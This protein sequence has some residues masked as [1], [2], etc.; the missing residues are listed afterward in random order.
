[1]LWWFKIR[2]CVDI[3]DRSI[4]TDGSTE[5]AVAG[6]WNE[7]FAENDCHNQNKDDDRNSTDTNANVEIK[8]R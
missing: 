8:A 4:V 6:R 2:F 3:V 1:M 7:T 5:I